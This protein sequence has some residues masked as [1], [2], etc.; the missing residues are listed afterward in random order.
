MQRSLEA[1]TEILDSAHAFGARNP[2]Y[3]RLDLNAE[4]HF[5]WNGSSFTIYASVLNALNIK[6][7]V[8]H[9]FRFSYDSS[10]NL[11]GTINEDYDVPIIPIIGLKYEF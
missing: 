9:F 2:P 8:D 11:I 3:V 4:F 10:G 6:N 5:N 7:V 1:G